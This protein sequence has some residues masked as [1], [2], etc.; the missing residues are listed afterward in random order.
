MTL[1]SPFIIT[2]RL[3]P[4]LRVGEAFVSLTW[5]RRPGEGGRVRFAWTVDLVDGASLTGDDLQSGCGGGSLQDG[6]RSLLG[7]LCAF[8]ESI[9]YQER[10]G[11]Q[12]ENADLFPAEL[13]PWATMNSDELAMLALELDER[14]EETLIDEKECAL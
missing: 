9:Q 3:L 10:T 14:R 6:F 13:A 1:A 12:G 5:S 7:F 8:A 11:R 4:G 2:P